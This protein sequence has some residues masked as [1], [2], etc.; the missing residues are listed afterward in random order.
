MS[1]SN[2]GGTTATISAK[3]DNLLFV[4]GYLRMQEG[5]DFCTLQMLD[6]GS[7]GN[8][9]KGAIIRKGLPKAQTSDIAI[10]QLVDVTDECFHYEVAI[11]NLV[12][13]SEN[14]VKIIGYQDDP[15][16]MIMELC[17]GSLL[18]LI[19]RNGSAILANNMRLQAIK[20]IANGCKYIHSQRV[21][22]FDIKPAN[23]L[24]KWLSD[25]KYIFKVSDFGVTRL[26]KS[27]SIFKIVSFS[28][29]LV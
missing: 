23:I 17:D 27:E 9:Y 3:Q 5:I 24:F 16:M 26:F 2:T 8:L 18:D 28:S 22:H 15:N 1:S 11:S 29:F 25:S 7:T 21:I 4:P 10:K 13:N 12:S 14:V 20:D 19:M 6:S